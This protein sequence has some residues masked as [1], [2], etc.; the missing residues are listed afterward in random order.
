MLYALKFMFGVLL[1]AIF[2]PPY[3]VMICMALVG[4]WQRKRHV[5]LTLAMTSTLRK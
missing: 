1:L 5:R 2:G 4:D 3:L